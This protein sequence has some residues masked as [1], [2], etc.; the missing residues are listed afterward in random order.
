MKDPMGPEITIFVSCYNERHSIV[1]TIETVW[2][3]LTRLQLSAEILVIDD[4]SSDDSAE[5]VAAFAEKNPAVP[6]R[7]IRHAQ[8]EGLAAT[9]FEA[10]RLARGKYFWCVAGDNPVPEQ[11]CTT[12]LGELAKADIIIP[13]VVEY[14]GRS[15]LRRGLSD[16]YGTL[17]RLVS[18]SG[19]RYFNGS[20]I[21]L[22]EQ[23]LKHSD[24]PHGFGY[25][26]EMLIAL[27]GAGASFLELAVRYND[28]S[29]GKSTALGWSNFFEIGGMLLR[30][31]RRR[32]RPTRAGALPLPS[33]ERA[34]VRGAKVYREN[35]TPHPTPLP[36]G[37]GA[38]LS[39]Q[40]D[41]RN[42]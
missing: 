18:G 27:T 28:R 7:L 24:I 6:L 22:R 34:G 31:L 10:A 2:R 29:S 11:T 17:V 21:Y 23:F 1:P 19:I 14:A 33:G 9:I 40:R 42:V 12:L 20:S 26:A 35:V 38:G 16:A 3:A 32:F 30:L 15:A 37:E 39:L 5:V 25:S 41:A 4:C 8:N 36:K 13:Y